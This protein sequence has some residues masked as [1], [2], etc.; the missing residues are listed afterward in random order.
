MGESLGV[1]YDGLLADGPADEM[2]RALDAIV[3]IRAVQDLSPSAGVGFVFLLKQVI[4]EQLRGRDAD[5]ADRT[6]LAALFGRID[7]L[8]LEAFDLFMQ[9]REKIFQLRVREIRGRA[10]APLECPAARE[11]EGSDR[12]ERAGC[13]TKGGCAG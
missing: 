11:I 3:R 10:P 6:A 13:K 8:A 4:G 2:R 12:P 5:P 1:L 7:R 9:C